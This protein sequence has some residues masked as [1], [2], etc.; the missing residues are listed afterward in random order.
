MKAPSLYIYLSLFSLF[1]FLPCRLSRRPRIVH[2]VS[3][4]LDEWYFFPDDSNDS[5]DTTTTTVLRDTALKYNVSHLA[6]WA[7][8][9]R[10][11]WARPGKTT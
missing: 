10:H 2:E 5:M 3:V 11:G 1:L 7:K 8:C 4:S 9:I 6:I